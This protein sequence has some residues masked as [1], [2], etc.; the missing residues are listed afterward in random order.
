[1]RFLEPAHTFV[2]TCISVSSHPVVA[3][4]HAA[5]SRGH[6]LSSTFGNPVL[7]HA[8]EFKVESIEIWRV[9]PIIKDPFAEDEGLFFT[10]IIAITSPPPSHHLRHRVFHSPVRARVRACV[11]VSVCVCVCLCVSVC[12]SVWVGGVVVVV[13]VVCVC[14][15]GGGG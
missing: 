5:R 14:V 11:C 8:E 13:V 10:A 4:L 2:T 3:C 1:V 15:W 7:S 9:G 6:P 12:V